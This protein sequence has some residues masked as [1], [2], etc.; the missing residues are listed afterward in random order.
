MRRSKTEK[1]SG[2]PGRT[3]RRIQT[4]P[5]TAACQPTRP[6]ADAEFPLTGAVLERILRSSRCLLIAR[7]AA[8]AAHEI[9]NPVSAVVNL[10]SLMQSVLTDDGISAQK[11]TEFRSYVSQV[12]GEA[13]RAGRIASE[14]LAF[15]R[16]TSREPIRADLNGIVRRTLS[17]AVHLLKTEDV[18]SRLALSDGLPW[19]RCDSAQVQYGLLHMVINAAEAVEGR[20]RRQVTISTRLREDGRAVL[21]EVQDTGEGISSEHRPRIFE[22]FFTT[23]KRPENLGLGLTVARAV[24]EAHRGSVRVESGPGQATAVTLVLPVEDER[25]G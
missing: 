21:I 15:A 6:P 16:A 18:D 7:L 11:T 20:E 1:E 23:K 8:P 4:D 24:M 3:K 12:I 19:V 13:T 25:Q 17:L 10:A 5:D 14:M 22:P 9:I 2:A